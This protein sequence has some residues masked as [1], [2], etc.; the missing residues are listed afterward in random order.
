MDNTFTFTVPGYTITVV[1]TEP[2]AP[3]ATV[4]DVTQ[5]EELQVEETD[6]PAEVAPEAPTEPTA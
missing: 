2:I 5:G 4:V 3:A 6:A 1:G